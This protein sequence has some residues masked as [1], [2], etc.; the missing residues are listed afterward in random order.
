MT[1][2]N[3]IVQ[4]HSGCFWIRSRFKSCPSVLNGT[5]PGGSL[6]RSSGSTRRAARTGG[7]RCGPRR[8]R[9]SILL[10]RS[11]VYRGRNEFAG[12]YDSSALT[13]P[14]L[15][16]EDCSPALWG[17]LDDSRPIIMINLEKAVEP[18][19]NTDGHRCRRICVESQLHLEDEPCQ[20]VLSVFIRV[21]PW[22]TNSCSS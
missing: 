1:A 4:A 22:L 18:R 20:T 13:F 12:R 15:G 2:G 7:T 9:S 11:K 6:P 16:A 10:H 5:L 3:C 19:M 21:Y 14:G 8:E 17:R